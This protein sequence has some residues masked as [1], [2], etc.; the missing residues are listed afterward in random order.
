[1]PAN[2]WDALEPHDKM[3]IRRWIIQSALG[4][5][6]FGVVVFLSAGRLNWIWG[7]IW[8]MAL[9]GFLAAH[10]LIL[11]PR[12]PAL[13]V[14]RGQGMGQEGVKRWD[15]ILIGAA[16]IM[17]LATW[18]VAG[19]D[20][21]YG[22]TTS[23]PSII[24][25]AGLALLVAGYA[26]FL[27]AMASNSFFAEGVRIQTERGHNVATRGPYRFVRHPGYTG[28]I[29]SELATPLLLGST[30]ALIPAVVFAGAYILRTALEDRTLQ[31]ELPGYLEFTRKIRF[32]LLPGL[33]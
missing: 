2:A 22:W 17:M 16:G 12:D 23:F 5:I 8:F 18:I 30:L 28:A 13:L 11:V 33:W 7:W 4:Q 32:R 24:N 21:R 26:L 9:A 1:M 10:P 3:M 25:L 27:W 29:L 19:L 6:G 15:R 20:L 14:E 31:Q